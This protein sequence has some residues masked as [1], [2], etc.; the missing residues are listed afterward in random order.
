MEHADI[1]IAGAGVIGLAAALELA[2]AG[3]TVAVFER[4]EA[5]RESSWAAAGMLAACD[6][7]NPPAM[8]PLAR[9]SLGL[10]SEFLA[11]VERFSGMKVPVRT[12]RTLQGAHALP[13]GAEEALIETTQSIAPGLRRGG[14][15]FFLL[16]EQSIDP[17]DLA[18]ALPEAVK[19]AGVALHEETAVTAV[20]SE[21]NRV[22]IATTGGE[23][24]ASHFVNACGAWA[25]E[26]ADVP[27]RPRKGQMLLVECAEPLP[28]TVRVPHLYLVPR[29]N[30]RVVIGATVEDSGFDKRVDPAVMDALRTAAADLWPPIREARVV[31][32]W[33][34]L[35][36]AASDGVPVIGAS[37][38]SGCWLA[39]G[40]FRNGIML[41]P[42]T[43]RLLRQ[44]I[45]REPPD[46]DA[47]A[48]SAARFAASVA[49]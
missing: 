35:R 16:E 30:G 49:R 14:L 48:F 8:R 15:K 28:A 40:H 41:A 27:I 39:L 19:A 25:A 4:G 34:G 26:L 44:M 43:A 9:M 3:R 10:Y 31:D 1:A 6:P 12:T 29:G 38:E 23:W 11:R 32:A 47:D 18:R 37:A 13:P 20:R 7:E 22:R 45:L 17:R 33:A 24:E 36:P 42:G 5:M 21:K 2:D 46:I